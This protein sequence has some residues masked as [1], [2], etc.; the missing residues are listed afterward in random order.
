MHR[1][2][3]GCESPGGSRTAAEVVVWNDAGGEC[4]G[5]RLFGETLLGRKGTFAP[6]ALWDAKRGTRCA[7]HSDDL[8]FM[9]RRAALMEMVMHLWKKYELKVRATLGDD[10]GDDVKLCI[11]KGSRGEWTAASSMRPTQ[12]M[13]RRSA[14]PR[15]S[16]RT[17]RVWANPSS[18]SR[19]GADAHSLDDQLGEKEAARSRT[20]VA[21][22]NYLSA[23]WPDVAFAVKELC[24]EM[25]KPTSSS[26]SR[27]KRVAR[28]LLHCPRLL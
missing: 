4:M 2:A 25:S 9:G 26:L 22:A 13:L 14:T 23:D 17:R 5:G 6:A 16:G 8:T 3:G 28:Y 15:V 11:L 27:G 12:S 10:P 24:R 19:R 21:T 18:G 1:V 20:L 7:V